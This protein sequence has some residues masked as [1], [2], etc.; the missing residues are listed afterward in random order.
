MLPRAARKR[1]SHL[2]PHLPPSTSLIPLLNGINLHT[3]KCPHNHRRTFSSTS[4]S[5]TSSR[6]SLKPYYTSDNDNPRTRETEYEV[7]DDLLFPTGY[8]E[9]SAAVKHNPQPSNDDNGD[10]KPALVGVLSNLLRTLPPSAIARSPPP[11]SSYTPSP[12]SSPS[13][14]KSTALYNPIWNAPF[15]PTPPSIPSTLSFLT[16]LRST[17]FTALNSTSS[18]A[19]NS[20]SFPSTLSDTAYKDWQ[21]YFHTERH[22]DGFQGRTA[23]SRALVFYYNIPPEAEWREVGRALGRWGCVTRVWGVVK[24]RPHPGHRQRQGQGRG[25]GWEWEEE[26]GRKEGEKEGG[27]ERV[28]ER[29]NDHV[30]V[31]VEFASAEDTRAVLTRCMGH[32]FGWRMVSGKRHYKHLD[33]KVPVML[34]DYAEEN[35]VREQFEFE[36]EMRQGEGEEGKRK[37]KKRR[38]V[39]FTWIYVHRWRGTKGRLEE[40]FRGAKGFERVV[41]EDQIKSKPWRA[42]Y[43]KFARPLHAQIALQTFQGHLVDLSSP[44]PSSLTYVQHQNESQDPYTLILSPDL[45]PYFLDQQRDEEMRVCLGKGK[46]KRGG[47]GKREEGPRAWWDFGSVEDRQHVGKEGMEGWRDINGYGGKEEE[48][49][50]EVRYQFVLK[51]IVMG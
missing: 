40:V 46:G 47:N 21:S 24:R 15:P 18:T 45:P 51:P 19:P 8:D 37:E 2:H 13:A 6:R 34:W 48:E 17:S 36:R 43:I 5:N 1:V 29:E 39:P 44:S 10:D 7:D 33:G 9:A 35:S 12:S 32:G 27:K 28:G 38:K 4:T 3:F 14:P 25:Q 42:A 41:V 22:I 23:R 11:P 26:E 50:K 31:F 20:T 16:H 49:E 30:K